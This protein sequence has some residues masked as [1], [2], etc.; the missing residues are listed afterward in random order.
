MQHGTIDLYSCIAS[1]SRQFFKRVFYLQQVIVITGNP[2][3]G[4]RGKLPPLLPL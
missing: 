3:G 4:G 2:F 1:E